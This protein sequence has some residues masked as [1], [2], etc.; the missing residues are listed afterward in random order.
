MLGKKSG[1]A[2]IKIKL[3]EL[4]LSAPEDKQAAILEQVKT[5][6]TTKKRLV[7]DEEFRAI[8]AQTA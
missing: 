3:E 2:N 1:L 7:T 4:G 6:G 5:I 8:V